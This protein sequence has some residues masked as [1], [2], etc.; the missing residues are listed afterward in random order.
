MPLKTLDHVNVRTANLAPMIAFYRDVMG[1]ESGWRPNFPFD[2]AWMYLEGK[3]IVHLVEVPEDPANEAPKL[4]HFAIGAEDMAGFRA[5]LDAHDVAYTVDPVPG[6]ELVQ[7]NLRDPDGNHIH[8]D[9]D[10]AEMG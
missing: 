10:K 8:V 5:T 1:M 3:P 7:I 2:G 9:F 4:E 6:I